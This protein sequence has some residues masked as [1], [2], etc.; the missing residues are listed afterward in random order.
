[1][2]TLNCVLFSLRNTP[3]PI[4]FPPRGD[5]NERIT[6]QQKCEKKT[7]VLMYS[8]LLRFSILVSCFMRRCFYENIPLHWIQEDALGCMGLGC[9]QNIFWSAWIGKLVLASLSSVASFSPY[10]RRSVKFKK[11]LFFL[12]PVFVSLPFFAWGKE[13]AVYFHFND[14]HFLFKRKKKKRFSSERSAKKASA[15]GLALPSAK[16]NPTTYC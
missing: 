10:L 3:P 9:L 5:E 12:P 14:T 13:K 7:Y 2:S 11:R 16:N 6:Q 8:D 4:L 15:K 1:M